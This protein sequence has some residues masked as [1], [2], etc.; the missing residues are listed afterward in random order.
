MFGPGMEQ[1]TARS[2]GRTKKREPAAGP[3]QPS[4][5][6]R[7]AGGSQAH[8]PLLRHR[9]TPLLRTEPSCTAPGPT[10]G[11][12]LL[13]YRL[14]SPDSTSRGPL[15]LPTRLS[16]PDSTSQGFILHQSLEGGVDR[17]YSCTDTRG[18]MP[19]YS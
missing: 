19:Q 13:P 16:S 9:T 12:L 5:S 14:S 17:V 2:R 10:L 18:K 8:C 1:H 11:P 6:R 4:V 3:E 15:L 7:A